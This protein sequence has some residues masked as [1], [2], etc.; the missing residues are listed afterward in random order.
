M[1]KIYAH[2]QTKISK[3]HIREYL[4]PQDNTMAGRFIVLLAMALSVPP[5]LGLWVISLN[6]ESHCDERQFVP[7]TSS[8]WM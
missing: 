7:S 4:H 8:T 1:V 2:F 3:K 5:K 6:S